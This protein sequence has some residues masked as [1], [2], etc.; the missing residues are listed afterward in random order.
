MSGVPRQGSHSN[1]TA[2]LVARNER[3]PHVSKEGWQVSTF[4]IC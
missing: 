3:F 2:L 4:R 1:M